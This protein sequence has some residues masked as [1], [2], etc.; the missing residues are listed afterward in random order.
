MANEPFFLAV[1]KNLADLQNRTEPTR[2]S[3]ILHVIPM[4]QNPANDGNEQKTQETVQHDDSSTSKQVELDHVYAQ[5]LQGIQDRQDAL[6]AQVLEDRRGS[7]R[8]HMEEKDAKD[9]ED[10]DEKEEG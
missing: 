3:S 2:H 6:H 10:R 9:D 5:I 1:V 8:L 4:H 7:M